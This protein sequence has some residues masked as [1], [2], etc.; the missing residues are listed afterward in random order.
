MKKILEIF[1]IICFVILFPL[2][3]ILRFS[4][5]NGVALVP[6]D[7]GV[8][9]LLCLW[10]PVVWLRK[11]VFSKTLRA[12]IFF[13]IICISTLLLNPL[14]LKLP[15]LLVSSLYIFRWVFYASIFVLMSLSDEKL[16]KKIAPLLIWCGAIM[17]FGGFFQFFFYPALRNLLYL[18]WDEH[19]RRMF[20]SFLDPNFLGAFF[21]LYIFYLLGLLLQGKIAGRLRLL[22]IALTIV[23]IIALVL[24]FSRGSY[25]MFLTGI[26][27]GGFLMGYKKFAFGITGIAVLL[28]VSYFLFVK[29]PSEGM[30]L[31]RSTS[32]NARLGSASTAMQIYL[33]H[34]VFGVGFDAYRYAQ[35]QTG[36]VSPQDWDTTHAG[37]GTDNSFLFVL[38]TTGIVGLLAYLFIGVTILKS[39]WQKR[40]K[41]AYSI[42]VIVSLVGL[43]IDS[44]SINAL[45]YSFI[46][47][48]LWILVGMI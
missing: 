12:I 32:A 4:F 31:L 48:W 16:K 11:A 38:A 28:L 36:T 17:V 9:I 24:T 26:L 23:S 37:A 39:A 1:F 45:F 22:L 29:N 5:G 15:E 44:F 21:N 40:K 18:G 10:V 34:P 8:L 14:H 42:I 7:I 25:L 35:R 41:N 3:E 43:A 2:G 27:A 47:L 30:N 20:G 6:L 33:H 13:V 19:Y 46:M